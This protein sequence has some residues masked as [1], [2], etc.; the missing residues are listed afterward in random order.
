MMVGPSATGKTE[1][2][3]ILLAALGR[4]EGSEGVSYV[5]DPKAISENSLY[6]TLDPT[7]WEWNNGL[8]TNILQKV[9]DNVRGQDTKQ[10]WITFY[11]DVDPK[12]VENL[13]R[14]CSALFLLNCFI[15]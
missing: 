8:F 4:L 3:K 9:I 15:G 11:G 1:A 13:N 14:C 6:N 7:T 10:H 5:I 12:W 2:W